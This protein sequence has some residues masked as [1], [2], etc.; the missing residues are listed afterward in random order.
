MKD[1]GELLLPEHLRYAKDHEWVSASA[2]YRVGISDFAQD[3]LGD[4]TFVELPETGKTVAMGDEFGTL[5]SI[6]SVSTLYIPVDAK[7]VAVNTALESDPGLV[8]SDPYG[9]GW[10]VEIEPAN[11]AQFDALMDGATY[12]QHLEHNA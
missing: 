6:K 9:E 2:P 4:L 3:Q 11:P 7:I 5:E 10:L 1:I 12:R 8:N